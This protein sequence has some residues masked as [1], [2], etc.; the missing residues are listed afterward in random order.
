M[1]TQA[2]LAIENTKH[3]SFRGQD[4][5]NKRKCKFKGPQG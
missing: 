5:T 4:D 1:K 3:S 2:Q